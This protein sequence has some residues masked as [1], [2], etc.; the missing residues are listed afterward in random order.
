[1]TKVCK[2]CR[3]NKSLGQFYRQKSGKFGHSTIC[4]PCWNQRCAIYNAAHPERIRVANRKYRKE[5]QFR[6]RELTRKSA[7][8]IRY[9]LTPEDYATMVSAQGG[10]CAICG[11]CPPKGRRLCVDHCHE[12]NRPRKLL[13]DK[14]NRG[15]GCFNDDSQLIQKAL[16]Y[17]EANTAE[18]LRAWMETKP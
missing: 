17:I 1:M 4:K 11:T 3:L 8:K 10:Y 13:C 5:N 6:M 18:V 16:K 2:D 14:C 15:I 12:T 7:L 9:G